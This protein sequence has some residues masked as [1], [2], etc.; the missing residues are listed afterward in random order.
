VLGGTS[1]GNGVVLMGIPEVAVLALLTLFH[2]LNDGLG[3]AVDWEVAFKLGVVVILVATAVA[4][5]SSLLSLLFILF[6]LFCSAE[7][8]VMVMVG[9]LLGQGGVLGFVLL[10]SIVGAVMWL[11]LGSLVHGGAIVGLKKLVIDEFLPVFVPIFLV[12]SEWLLEVL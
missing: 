3:V 9:P 10:F 4:V 5:D 12:L 7:V 2:G 1:F 8:K 6:I 11:L